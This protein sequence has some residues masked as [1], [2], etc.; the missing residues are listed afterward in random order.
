MIGKTRWTAFT[1][2]YAKRI[3]ELQDDGMD[4]HG[5][6]HLKNQMA[7]LEEYPN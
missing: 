4:Q 5:T 6:V 2:F 1:D 7:A 3:K